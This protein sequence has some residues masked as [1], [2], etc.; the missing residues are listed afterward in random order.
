MTHVERALTEDPELARYLLQLTRER[1]RE[2]QRLS[3]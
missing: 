3:E 1:A 2:L